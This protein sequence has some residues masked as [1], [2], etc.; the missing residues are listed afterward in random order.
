MSLLMV[1]QFKAGAIVMKF[2]WPNS[3]LAGHRRR[4]RSDPR[5]RR[6]SGRRADDRGRCPGREAN[7]QKTVARQWDVRYLIGLTVFAITVVGYTL[8][9]GFLA[10]VWTD[11]FQSVLM[12]FG[13]V[14]LFVLIVPATSHAGFRPADARRRPRHRAEAFASGPGYSASG[15]SF[16][17]PTLA[18]SYFVLWVFAGLGTPAA[19]IR[20]MAAKNTQTL[21][22]SIVVLSLYNLLIYLP[23]LLICVCA[24]SIFPRA[25]EIRRSHSPAGP[26][27]HTWPAGR[28]AV[29]RNHS[30][31]PAGSG[32]VDGQL[33]SD[34]DRLGP[35]PRCLPTLSSPAASEAEVR[36]ASHVV[37][38]VLGVAAVAASIDPVKYLQS[39]VVFSAAACGATFF[40][41]AW[42][43][44]YWPRAT[45]AGT[46]AAML[47]GA[48]TTLGL[49]ITGLILRHY[50]WQQLINH[51]ADYWSFYPLGFHPVVFGIA[52]SL[53]AGVL[54]SLGTKPPPRP[55]WPACFSP[56]RPRP[57]RVGGHRLDSER[58]QAPGRSRLIRQISPRRATFS[59]PPRRRRPIQIRCAGVRRSH[60]G[61]G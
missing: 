37:M 51:E 36:R 27:G 31:C 46:G 22:R 38:I 59:H 54:V 10:S 28:I 29:G 57:G 8:I 33:V 39:L 32:D 1:A 6:D 47:A 4:R 61:L 13:V 18:L 5:H 58:P 19:L 49:F 52:A 45:A 25:R 43:M 11:M 21:R 56:P 24:R 3:N 30:G 55:C 44:A 2:A 42:M 12:A 35:G 15:R 40:V 50:G 17:P 34:R 9:G 60:S 7:P 23:L 26:V 48:G 20:V 14:L 53:A 41:P 16:L